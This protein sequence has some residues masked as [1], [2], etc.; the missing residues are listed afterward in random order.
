MSLSALANLISNSVMTIEK[1]IIESVKKTHHHHKNHRFQPVTPYE[2][3]EAVDLIVAA[4]A[5]LTSKVQDSTG[6]VCK[7]ALG[8]NVSSAIRVAVEGHLPEILREAGPDGLDIKEIASRCDANPDRLQ[9]IMRL[10]VSHHIFTSPKKG[11][12]ANNRHSLALD[13]GK[14]FQDLPRELNSEKYMGPNTLPALIAHSTDEM[15]KSSSYLTECILEP[16]NSRLFFGDQSPFSHAFETGMDFQ[17]FL[18]LSF[19]QEVRLRRFIAATECLSRIGA[20]DQGLSGYNWSTMGNGLLVDIA[21]GVGHVALSLA[22]SFPN[23]RIVLQDRSEVITLAQAFWQKNFPQAIYTKRVML[24]PH[25]LFD[26]QTRK[27]AKVFFVRFVIREWNDEQAI[28]ILKNLSDA[29]SS[30]TKLILVERTVTNW[31]LD[32]VHECPLQTLELLK[33]VKVPKNV[34]SSF[35][36]DIDHPQ[37]LEETGRPLMDL[38]D[39]QLMLYGS[40]R[41][42]TL[43]EL[44][45]ILNEANWKVERINRPGTSSLTQLTCRRILKTDDADSWVGGWDKKPISGDQVV[46]SNKVNISQ[47]TDKTCE[48]M[49]KSAEDSQIPGLEQTETKKIQSNEE[50][51]TKEPIFPIEA[52][53]NN[54]NSP[55]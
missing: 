38:L 29:S 13:T 19:D 52:E 41:E 3:L 16:S 51:E 5:E 18:Q 31:S 12:F 21:G 24:E 54:L 45:V 2:V 37:V 50:N 20:S 6:F 35:C 11:R 9:R 36:H 55:D 1:A 8:F 49:V 7:L 15:F 47:E 26:R 44:V 17:T 33:G 39:A 28:K 48:N 14:P 40:G 10:L 25:N 53:E 43:E 4:C 30:A 27:G 22:Q 23:L 42:R 46:P 34:Q 32:S